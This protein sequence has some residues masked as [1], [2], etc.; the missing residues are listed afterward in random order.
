MHFSPLSPIKLC[1]RHTSAVLTPPPDSRNQVPS[2]RLKCQLVFRRQ[3]VEFVFVS[4]G[5]FC[6][7]S[8]IVI[9]HRHPVPLARQSIATQNI[10]ALRCIDLSP[11]PTCRRSLQIRAERCLVRSPLRCPLLKARVATRRNEASALYSASN[12]SSL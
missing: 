8:V 12:V 1:E 7:L 6:I 2:H 9:K 5:A 11:D 10:A 3:K 4:V